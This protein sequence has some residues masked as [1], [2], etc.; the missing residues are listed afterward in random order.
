[1][2]RKLR[3][4]STKDR[5]SLARLLAIVQSHSFAR[6]V[7]PSIS[8]LCS[9]CLLLGVPSSHSNIKY[10]SRHS[11]EK[12]RGTTYLV[13][14][15]LNILVCGFVIS[16]LRCTNISHSHSTYYFNPLGHPSSST[17]LFSF[18]RQRPD[19]KLFYGPGIGRYLD[20][21]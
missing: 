10:P 3:L 1:M 17:P 19:N 16:F 9:S 7:D 14:L 20:N 21:I 4:H 12:K 15:Y 8:M 6:Q 5:K 11:V 13:V 2:L 18:G